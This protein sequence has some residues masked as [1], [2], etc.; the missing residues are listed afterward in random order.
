MQ[1][2]KITNRDLES[3]PKGVR[4]GDYAKK[5]LSVQIVLEKQQSSTTFKFLKK[6]A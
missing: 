5:I 4:G 1:M 6:N 3:Q 2:A